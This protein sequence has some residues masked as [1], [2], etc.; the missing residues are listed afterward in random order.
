MNIL[1]IDNECL[2]L[3]SL[4]NAVTAAEPGA[5]IRGFTRVSE[6]LIAVEQNGY[7]PDVAFLDIEMPGM[8]GI[9]LASRIKKASPETW[10]I[11]VTGFSQ[12]AL[13]AFSVHAGGYL[14]KPTTPERIREEL[15]QVGIRQQLPRKAEQLL[16]VHCFGNFEVFSAGAPVVFSRKKAK[17][18]FAYLVH[19]R[20]A[21]C[22]TRE[23]AAVLFED[24]PYDL[25]RQ[26]YLQTIIASMHRSLKDVGGE[27]VVSRTFGSL[28][29]DT[30][31]IDCDYYRFLSMD[32][33]AINSY[34]GEYMSQYEWGEF[35]LDYLNQQK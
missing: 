24:A 23:I 25:T 32:L 6:A 33:A 31:L 27:S 11:F 17:E 35:T 15:D 12:Y 8:T 29:V 13:E 18:L 16:E 10:L 9:E 26:S 2:A 14:L 4:N 34:T 21:A 5:A 3:D 19:K 30:S 7:R 1:T 20:G 22:A 28:A